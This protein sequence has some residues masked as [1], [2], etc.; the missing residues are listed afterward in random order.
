VKWPRV[1]FKSAQSVLYGGLWRGDLRAEAEKSPL[2][3]DV[4]RERLL[5]TGEDLA[6]LIC[7]VWRLAMAL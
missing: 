1:T 5:N 3:E 2:L 7:K 4:T 6:M